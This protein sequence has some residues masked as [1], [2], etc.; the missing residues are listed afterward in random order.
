MCTK[1]LATSSFARATASGVSSFST[2]S[3]RLELPHTA[4]R[5]AATGRPTMPVPGMPTP[6]PFLRML[7]LTAT[8]SLKSAFMR[9]EPQQGQFSE[10]ISAALATASATAMGSVQPSA[11]FTSCL[12]RPMISA[13]VIRS[14]SLQ[15]RLY[16]GYSPAGPAECSPPRPG[17]NSWAG[18]LRQSAPAPGGSLRGPHP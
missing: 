8:S 11:G 4:P 5:A 6:M 3:P 9:Q 13:C 2:S 15:T 10:I 17:G 1:P 12:M 14:K 16:P 18:S 7:P